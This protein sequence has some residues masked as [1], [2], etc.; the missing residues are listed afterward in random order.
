MSRLR[1]Q[2]LRLRWRTHCGWLSQWERCVPL[3]AHCWQ[4]WSV[5]ITN[6]NEMPEYIY[7]SWYIRILYI[8]VLE[9]KR[10]DGGTCSDSVL[11]RM[12]WQMPDEKNED[13][14]KNKLSHLTRN[15]QDLRIQNCFFCCPVLGII[16]VTEVQWFV[17]E[18]PLC[19][20]LWLGP[21]FLILLLLTALPWMPSRCVLWRIWSSVRLLGNFM[22]SF[23]PVIC[24]Y[25]LELPRG[26]Y[27]SFW[28]Y[29]D[30]PFTQSGEFLGRISLT[31]SARKL[32]WK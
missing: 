8:L 27:R 9:I 22:L 2:W 4:D 26:E 16:E 1:R 32:R 20:D 6:Y 23:V 5:F 25:Q 13:M 12:L 18:Y 19:Y 14:C 7:I 30:I 15:G 24:S 10:H 3:G 31:S 11:V 29:P 28:G 17:H 21:H